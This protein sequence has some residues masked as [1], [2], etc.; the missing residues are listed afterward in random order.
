MIIG[1]DLGT[2][3]SLV[4]FFRD[5][6]SVPVV[7]ALGS[8]L[9]PSAVGI[10]DDGTV[11]IGNAA[12]ERLITHPHLTVASFKRYMGS[13][14]KCKLGHQE[15]RA[16]ELS[17]LVLKSLKEDAENALGEKVSEA[18]I[19]V[20]AYF[21]DAQRKATK[22]AGRLAGLKVERLLNEPTAAA[23]AYGLNEREEGSFLVLDL[24]G[25]TF[26]V[27]LLEMFDGVMEVHAC[28]GDNAL[29]GNDFDR[30]LIDLFLESHKE[31]LGSSLSALDPALKNHLFKQA[32]KVKCALTHEKESAFQV[33][34][35]GQDLVQPIT[36]TRFEQACEPL[37]RRLRNPIE[38]ALNDAR[39]NPAS[40]DDF[41]LVGGATRMP[42][43][44][45]LSGLVFG[46]I[47]NRK[48]DPDTTIAVG[49]AIQA[50]M[51]MKDKSLDE[52]VLTD[53]APYS[54]GVSSLS[55][56]PDGHSQIVFTP[57][58]ERNTVVPCSRQ[59]EFYSIEKNQ[60]K[61][62][63]KVYQ[64]ENRDPDKNILLGKLTIDLPKSTPEG[65]PLNCRFT[66]DM[67]GLLEVEASLPQTGEKHTLIIHEN[68]GLLNDLEI[69]TRLERLSKLKIH[70]REH[71][72]N[73]TLLA[74]AERLYEQTLG[75]IRQR[76]GSNIDIF[77]SILSGQDPNKIKRAAQE[78]SMFLDNVE[79]NLF[80]FE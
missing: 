41:V 40:L 4:G 65:Y 34:Y 10:D 18:V 44:A 55:Q 7:N 51:K 63:F 6:R 28:A 74:R 38:K 22:N 5:G 15:F 46:R 75:E 3:N 72:V 76:V 2:T 39:L 45:R 53:V 32:E 35:K 58:I 33:K 37:L 57:I 27:T 70:P 43:I 50:G 17:A 9:T 21:N 16:E 31:V 48:I 62:T 61:V 11:L 66:Y 42:M 78:L 8:L 59:E 80:Y 13:D 14:W 77:Q 71:L 56:T 69:Q 79:A 67:D 12:K 68:P 49:A 47:P 19:T 26:D 36:R 54:L 1:I 60:K 20:P 30:I 23:M 24:G 64:G 73:R 25:G 29:G 52:V